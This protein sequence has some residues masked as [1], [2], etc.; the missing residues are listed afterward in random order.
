MISVLPVFIVYIV[1]NRR[2][3]DALVQGA[4]KG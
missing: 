3:E 4:V 1:L 2:M